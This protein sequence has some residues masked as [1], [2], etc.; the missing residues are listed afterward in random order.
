MNIQGTQYQDWNQNCEIRK[1]S[2]NAAKPR[3]ND[4]NTKDSTGPLDYAQDEKKKV[5]RTLSK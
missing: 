3:L 4:G 5:H 1:M 2:E